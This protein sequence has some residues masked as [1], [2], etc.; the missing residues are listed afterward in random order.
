MV[1]NLSSLSYLIFSLQLALLS[2]FP[3]LQTFLFFFFL[4]F[5]F[6]LSSYTSFPLTAVLK[7]FHCCIFIC[8]LDCFTLLVPAVFT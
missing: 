1:N 5:F 6:I 2:L 3:D 7:E 8:E 4:S